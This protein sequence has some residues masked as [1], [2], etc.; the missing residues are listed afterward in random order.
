MDNKLKWMI[1][2]VPALMLIALPMTSMGAKRSFGKWWYLPNISER[3]QLNDAEKKE[4]DRL[5][6]ENRR[7]LI[8][9]KSVVEKERFEL[10]NLMEQTRLDEDAVMKQFNK[11][12]KARANLSAERF[13]FFLE[14]RKVLGAERYKSLKMLFKTFREKRRHAKGERVP[15]GIPAKGGKK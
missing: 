14:I 2:M 11:L 7:S 12:E 9:L 15:G 1:V 8:D 4:L 13:R 3:L 10:D 5:Y 6:V